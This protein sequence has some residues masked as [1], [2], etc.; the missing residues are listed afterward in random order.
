MRVFW[1][2]MVCVYFAVLCAM[3]RDWSRHVLSPVIG[4]KRVLWPLAA[5]HELIQSQ[6]RTSSQL[7]LMRTMHQH[8]LST[9][10]CLPRPPLYA[11]RSS[12]RRRCHSQRLSPR[13]QRSQCLSWVCLA[14]QCSLPTAPNQRTEIL[15]DISGARELGKHQS[16]IK[17][18]LALKRFKSR[19]ELDDCPRVATFVAF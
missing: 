16:I 13:S 14:M 3:E 12:M 17:I 6:P 2:D 15:D 9:A 11:R 5:V 19:F 7:N 4:R 10:A 18:N 1:S 8:T